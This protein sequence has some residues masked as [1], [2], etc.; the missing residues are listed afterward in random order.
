MI[1]ADPRLMPFTLGVTVGVVDPPGKKI[2]FGV[3]VTVDG[4]L[5]ASATY[6]PPAAAGT[7]RVTGNGVEPPGGGV[8]PACKMI[9]LKLI[10]ENTAGVPTPATDAVTM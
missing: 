9:P 10:S 5:L 7:P 3:M 8:I 4:S 1:V 2:L 6:T